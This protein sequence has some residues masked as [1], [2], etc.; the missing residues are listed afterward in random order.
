MTDWTAGYVADVEYT[1]GYYTEL[2]PAR[3]EFAL[4]NAG[5]MSGEIKTACELGF[6]QG[7]STNLH[8]AASDVEWHGT[9]FNPVQ[10]FA[11]QQL[12]SAAGI[13][14]HLYDQAFEEYANRRDL[15]DFD[16]IALHGI[17]SW[18]SNDNRK[19]IVDFINRKLKVGGVV[20]ISY[21]TLPGW[22]AFAP[23]RHLMTRHSEVL[24]QKGAGTLGRVTEA[25]AFAQK[26][27]SV[28]SIYRR[29]NPQLEEK[30]KELENKPREY[31]A[32]EY[33]NKD[34][35]PMYFSDVAD[36]LAEG[37]LTYATSA[38]YL[39][40]VPAVNY[41]PEAI[42]ILDNIPDRQFK[43]GVADFL[44]NRQFR[45]DYWIK[46]GQQL[47]STERAHGC[48]MLGWCCRAQTRRLRKRWRPI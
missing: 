31:L 11:A 3:V 17:W 5:L 40:H 21:N 30:V 43:E 25:V 44:V 47:G 12:S 39:E 10:A 37:K 29:V 48:E 6:G 2:N 41:T 28:D 33:F 23:M 19:V 46:G 14:T 8:A 27:L 16:F 32:H 45:K 38:S 26:M 4:L 9:D 7:L 34:W 15:P 42:K 24:G 20:Y 36:S 1:H 18:I 35:Q 13:K 22:S